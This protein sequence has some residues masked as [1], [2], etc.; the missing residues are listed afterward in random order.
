[1]GNDQFRL[2]LLPTNFKKVGLGVLVL[3]VLFFFLRISDVLT[4]DKLLVLIIT[5]TGVLVSLLLLAL[6]KNKVEDELTSRIR[7]NAFASSFIFGV[8]I[9]IVEPFVKLLFHHRFFSD[10][11]ATGL[12]IAMF[13]FYFG[14]YYSMLKKR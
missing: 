8:G 9:I 6:T 4:I 12:L 14:T 3:S 10:T 11:G 1:M 13:I 5:K 2:R 7:L